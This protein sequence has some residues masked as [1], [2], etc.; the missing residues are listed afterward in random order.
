MAAVVA[1][2]QRPNVTRKVNG[3]PKRPLDPDGYVAV[4]DPDGVQLKPLRLRRSDATI[5]AS[6]DQIYQ[7]ALIARVPPIKTAKRRRRGK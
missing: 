2:P 6:W 7:W 1:T 4:F 5:Y 3:R